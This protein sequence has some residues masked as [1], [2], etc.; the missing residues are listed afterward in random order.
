MEAL[1]RLR[2]AILEKEEI[3]DENCRDADQ[4]SDKSIRI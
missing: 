1:N 4:P 2:E 3:T